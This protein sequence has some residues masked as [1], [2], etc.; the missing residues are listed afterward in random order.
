MEL[1]RQTCQSKIGQQH[2]AAAIQHDVA[3]FQIAVQH[4][5]LMGRRQ[6]GAQPARDLERL[7]VG[8][9]ADPA[10]QRPQ[11]LAIDVLHREKQVAVDLADIVRAAD[12]RV[13]HLPSSADFIVET[14][15]GIRIACHRFGQKL[16]SDLLPQ[17][18]IVRPITSPMPP[19]PSNA[20]IR[21]RLARSTPGMNRLSS[22]DR[23]EFD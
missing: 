20:T 7:V 9:T 8:Q 18:Q 22:T 6:S 17:C 11:I 13:R 19:L 4:A 3:R 12:I 1:L 14:R 15:D 2:L 5:F 10:Q 21:Y 23:E 16:E